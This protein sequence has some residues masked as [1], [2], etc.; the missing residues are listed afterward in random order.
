MREQN[1]DFRARH[2]QVHKPGRRQLSRQLKTGEIIL[3]DN[4]TICAA[5]GRVAE[6]AADDIR[7]YFW[8]S[9]D[10]SLGMTKDPNKP[11]T[12]VLTAD[13]GPDK[14]FAL[15]VTENRVEVRLAS[16]DEAFR[17]IVYIEDYMNL[18]GA[19]VLPLGD[20]VRRPMF[21]WRSV[22]SGCG[23]DEYPDEELRAT[24]HAGYDAIIVFVK[25]FDKTAAGNC[26]INDIIERAAAFGIKTCL[27]NY[28]PFFVHPD[29]EGAQEK[30]DAIYGELFRRYPG[31][32]EIELVG[33]SLEFPSKDEHTTGKHYWESVIDGIPDTRVSPG[34]YPCRDYPAYLSL[35]EKAIHKVKP[36]A[37][38]VFSTYN[39]TSSPAELRR[40]FLSKVPK[41]FRIATVFENSAMRHIE[42]LNAPV[43]DYT[44]SQDEPG[45]YFITENQFAGEFGIP[46]EGN[47][48]TAGIAWDF[49]CVPYVPAPRK[50]INRLRWI[51]KANEEWGM[52]A[53]YATHHMGWWDC[54][55]SDLGKWSYWEDYEPDYDKLL[56]K[57]AVRDYGA[58]N[59]EKALKAW[60]CW[61][62]AM[63]Y[64]VASAEDQYGPWRVGA[65]Y[66]FIFQPNL[67]R[68]MLGKE[69]QFPTDPRA[70][71]GH[72]IIKTLYAPYDTI[73]QAPG[74][75]RM[76]AEIRALE[77]MEKIWSEGLSYA[78]SI[79]NVNDEAQQLWAL[80]QF[81]GCEIHTT[82]N[83]K[84]WWI[85]N[86]D[87]QRSRD[88]AEALVHMDELFRIL[89]D[90]KEN[91]LKAIPAAEADS[92][93]GW[94]P[95]MEYVC[96]PWH[97]DWKLRQMEAAGRE[98]DRYSTMLRTAEQGAREYMRQNS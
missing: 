93:L 13:S 40:D 9:M 84:R 72:R 41:G 3:S 43:R 28:I 50:L 5:A 4:W 87:L 25:D 52:D 33:E 91:V 94:E 69:I 26:N 22:H 60:E 38:I 85:E 97:L 90:E 14:G 2:W 62:E 30:A 23:I 35:I 54:V 11:Y 37:E 31:A 67:S 19:P 79:K 42:G 95:S 82:V 44:I 80:G 57:I 7:D 53:Q 21:K 27:Y 8:K 98:M 88:A 34:W 24:I 32:M 81:I 61:N 56:H 64:Y 96:D 78:A 16:D 89:A 71:F 92:R 55:S 68:T 45:D 51:R 39:W 46:T 48:N 49:G 83:I 18:E 74:F 12:I 6:R 29:E 10:L 17:A 1:Y 76:P 58:G 65:A 59:A 15:S 36:E 70:H 63:N 77:K 75:L 73:R 66:P 86:M 47:V 20:T